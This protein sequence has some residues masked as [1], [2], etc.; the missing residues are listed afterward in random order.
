M[1]MSSS[2]PIPTRR[3]LAIKRHADIVNVPKWKE[4]EMA[5][6]RN[7]PRATFYMNN[8]D[9]YI[10]DWKSGKKDGNGTYFYTVSGAVYQGEWSDDQRSGYGTYSIPVGPSSSTSMNTA[11]PDQRRS[12]DL[13]LLPSLQS[14]KGK[15]PPA[16]GKHRRPTPD[17]QLRK[18]YAGEWLYDVRHGRG[19]CFYDDGSAYDGMWEGDVRQGWGRM[20]YASDKS[21]YEGE[22]HQGQ[23]HGQGVLLLA[24]GDRYEGT[25]FNDLKE[26]PGKFIYR[27][28]RQAYEGEWALDMPKCGT[29][30]DLP[31]LVG[32]EGKGPGARAWWPIPPLTLKD[33]QSVIAMER[34]AILEE[35]LQRVMF[36]N[37]SQQ[38]PADVYGHE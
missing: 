15:S 9:R 10:G 13:P 14:L 38:Y 20:T 4:K 11:M 28:K 27:R 21:V 12:P 24:N 8:G 2:S 18:V 3:T 5:S 7:G 1:S 23:R 33:S 19:T 29:L 36:N 32:P 17:A 26:G 34:R 37:E 30:R 35:R 31:A 16:S 22:W 25:Y 6:L